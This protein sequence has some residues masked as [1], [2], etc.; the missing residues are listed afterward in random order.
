MRIRLLT[1]VALLLA[2]FPPSPAEAP[3]AEAAGKLCRIYCETIGVLCQAGAVPGLPRRLQRTGVG[4]L[5]RHEARKISQAPSPP[6]CSPG[7]FPRRKRIASAEA[8]TPVPT[9]DKNE[10]SI[11]TPTSHTTIPAAARP[12]W[13]R[14]QYRKSLSTIPP[15]LPPRPVSEP[16]AG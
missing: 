12:I 1:G 16:G 13:K 3:A 15:G 9:P 5:V 4:M 2:S 14:S 11:E 7:L 8:M 6:G 10:L